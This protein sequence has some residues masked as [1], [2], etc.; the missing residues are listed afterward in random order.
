MIVSEE[1]LEDVVV[2]DEN[3]VLVRIVHSHSPVAFDFRL[4]RQPAMRENNWLA[5][6][7]SQDD[8]RGATTRKKK[9]ENVIAWHAK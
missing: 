9:S 2:A 5:I 3:N 6:T 4:C 7:A 8:S 1:E